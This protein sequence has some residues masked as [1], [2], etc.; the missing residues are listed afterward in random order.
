MFTGKHTQG[1][2]ACGKGRDVWE[3]RCDGQFDGDPGW[4]HS[5]PSVI[6]LLPNTETS[7]AAVSTPHFGVSLPP[8]AIFGC[9]SL[10]R[11]ILSCRPGRVSQPQP[12]SLPVHKLVPPPATARTLPS[13]R[14][15]TPSWGLSWYLG[16][17]LSPGLPR[18]T[19]L[20]DLSGQGLHGQP[21]PWGPS[22]G[23]EGKRK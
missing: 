12:R 21:T 18:V 16:F 23:R 14:D 6:C 7:G 13:T 11:F 4:R 10:S 20:V 15:L 2:S 8:G 3:P 22:V 1:S 5:A 19:G 17:I 9:P